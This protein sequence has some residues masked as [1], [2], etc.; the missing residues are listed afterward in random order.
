MNSDF[1]QLEYN[2]SWREFKNQINEEIPIGIGLR[3]VSL[4]KYLAILSKGI[5]LGNTKF[6]LPSGQVDLISERNRIIRKI[7]NIFYQM[8]LGII[9]AE[10]SQNYNY[11]Q[12]LLGRIQA[13]LVR[14]NKPIF[15][16]G[17]R[18]RNA[19][20]QFVINDIKTRYPSLILDVITE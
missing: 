1:Y 12:L 9:E 10:Y 20:L 17:M 2:K 11:K 15:G 16:F 8:N 14:M 19:T 4:I 7:Q 3:R 6:N 18:Y 13:H 5:N